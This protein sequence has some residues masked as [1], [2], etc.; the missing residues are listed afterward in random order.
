MGCIS[1][2]TRYSRWLYRWKNE[3]RKK[4]STID[5][6]AGFTASLA[7]LIEFGLGRR[8]TIQILQFDR[9]WSKLAPIPNITVKF[10]KDGMSVET[11]SGLIWG[12]FCVSFKTNTTMKKLS[13]NAHGINTV[14]PKFLFAMD[15]KIGI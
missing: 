5:Y 12:S 10:V 1:W 7:A 6:N 13:I 15:L 4:W 8:D 11:G 9:A 14:G 3:L 2:R